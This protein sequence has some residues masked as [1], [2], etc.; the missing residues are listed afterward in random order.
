MKQKL[1]ATAAI[2]MLSFLASIHVLA[3]EYQTRGEIDCAFG[4]NIVWNLSDDGTLTLN[5]HWGGYYNNQ[6][7]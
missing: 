1:F 7:T 5:P 4:S 2:W 6:T 3:D